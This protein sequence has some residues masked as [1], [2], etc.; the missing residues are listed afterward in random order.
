MDSTFWTIFLFI[1]K[2]SLLAVALFP[3]FLVGLAIYIIVYRKWRVW[4]ADEI[5]RLREMWYQLPMDSHGLTGTT[6]H[7]LTGAIHDMDQGEWADAAHKLAALSGA[8]GHSATATKVVEE[9]APMVQLPSI[10]P[11]PEPRFKNEID[12]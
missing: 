6:I 10:T 9:E 7:L 11:M 12:L 2:I 3:L 8:H 1:G 4:Q 5:V